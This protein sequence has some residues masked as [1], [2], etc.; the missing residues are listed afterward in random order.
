M[1]AAVSLDEKAQILSS[2]FPN[3]EKCSVGPEDVPIEGGN[4]RVQ[5]TNTKSGISFLSSSLSPRSIPKLLLGLAFIYNLATAAFAEVPAVRIAVVPGG[6]SGMEQEVVD[7]ISADLQTNSKAKVSTVNP[8]WFVQCNIFDRTDTPG[9]SVRVNGTVVIKTPDG[10]ILNT[11]SMQTNK[12]DFSL[13]PGMPVNKALANK[14]VAEVINGLV[15]RVRQPLAE[16][17][18]IEIDTRE[19]LVTAQTL[20][21][22]DKFQEAIQKLTTVTQD[23][24]HFSGARKLL[25]IFQMEQDA[26][27]LVNQAKA[28]AAKGQYSQA[29]TALKGVDSKSRRHSL[30]LA[31]ISKY[32]AATLRRAPAR[33]AAVKKSS[34][35]AELDAQLKALEAQKKALDAQKR[36]VEAQEHAIQKK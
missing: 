32:K 33:P 25:E 30:A 1:F 36:A 28:L 20:A 2:S 31:L 29:I 22:E 7:R 8:D 6:G 9:A 10:H 19:K 21:D 24:P 17:I 14:G 13:S 16:A 3:F 5:I 4:L 27:E 23:S 12:Q 35:T 18:D 15:D 11:V 26:L 34:G